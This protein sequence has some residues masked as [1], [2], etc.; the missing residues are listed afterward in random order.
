VDLLADLDL[1]TAIFG[2]I[3]RPGTILGSLRSV[4]APALDG[5]TV[6]APACHDT[7]S[8]FASVDATGDTAFL[9]CGTWSLLGTEVSAPVITPLSRDLNFTNEG[10]VDDTFR[11]LKN[12]GGLWLLQGCRQAWERAGHAWSYDDLVRGAAENRHAFRAI[13]DPDDAAFLNPDDMVAAIDQYCRTTNQPVPEGP[14]GYTRAILESLAV[15]YRI[16]LDSLEEVS[17]RSFRTLHIVGGGSRNALLA[18]FTADATGRVVLAGP[19]E[20]TAL[21]NVAAQMVATGVAGSIRQ[22]RDVIARSFAFTRYEPRPASRWDEALE[23]LRDRTT[24]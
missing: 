22:A 21:G 19:V 8:A 5:T 2:D 18:Q 13:V 1:P 12:I 11:L 17:G 24:R 23:R 10:G 4:A 6:V 9:S 7:G 15:K 20:A 3:V 16:V 14:A